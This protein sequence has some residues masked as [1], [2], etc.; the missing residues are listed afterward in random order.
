MYINRWL[1]LVVVFFLGSLVITP[2]AAANEREQARVNVSIEGVSG[3]TATNVRNRLSIYPYHQEN[4]PG[5]S[6]LRYL[7]DLAFRDIRNAVTPYGF[8]QMELESSLE[9]ID[10][11]WQARYL[12]DLGPAITIGEV[13]IR[14]TGAGTNDSAFTNLV[15]RLNISPNATLLHADYERAKSRLRTLAAER[16]YYQA[17][18][19]QQELRIDL[20]SYRANIN[21]ELDSGPRYRF[22]E[23]SFSE[24]HLDHDVMQRFVNFEE[25]DYVNS[26]LLLDL[27]LGLSDSD[28]FNR[29]EVQPLWQEANDEYLVPVEITYEP[30]LRTNYSTG[31]GYGTDTGARLRFDL[32]RR[33]VNSRGHR[34]N[35]QIQLS[36]ALS[37]VAGNYIIPGRRPQTDQYAIRGLW[38]DEDTGN[39]ESERVSLGVSWQKQLTRT[40]RI[41][42]ID[43]LN[44]RDRLDGER[45]DSSFLLP[46]AQ[47]TRVHAENRLNVDDG[48]RL[49]LT[50]RGA[51]ESL[52]S[53]A[54][55]AQA[56]FSAK[57]VH[58]LSERWRFLSRGE[59]GTSLTNDF[60]RIPTSL[61]FYAGGDTSIRGYSYRSVGPRNDLDEVTGARHILTGSLEVDYEFRTNWRFA[62]FVDSGNAFNDIDEP[63]KTGAGF[64]LRWQSPIGPVRL[65]LAHAF[66]SPGDDIRVHLT[67][68]PDL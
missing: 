57:V 48:F 50:V 38:T 47:W 58:R 66:S 41:L 7:H 27:Q 54:D 30:I 52:F 56:T 39:T 19:T 13:N 43:W 45:R 67:I 65:D 68:G 64:G 32:N 6:R 11:V 4:A 8:Y 26:N 42:A 10:G 31:I 61:R 49:S 12:I 22:G 34:F 18:F 62:L 40:Q 28:Y 51:T 59:A 33:Y 9:L 1:Y 63:M 46:S 53:D 37:S 3:R 17:R 44:E 55:F 16:G 35:S 14:V 20:E 36:E 24:G 25:G 29:V 2:T 21:I 23:V 60:D 15:S 5:V